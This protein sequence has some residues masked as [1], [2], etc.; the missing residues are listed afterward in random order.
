MFL[1]VFILLAQGN[2]GYNELYNVFIDKN[3]ILFLMNILNLLIYTL[4]K[5]VKQ[6]TL[7][8]Q[9]YTIQLYLIFIYNNMFNI[10]FNFFTYHFFTIKHKIAEMYIFFFTRVIKRNRI[11]K[12]YYRFYSIDYLKI[13]FF[14]LFFIIFFLMWKR[15]N[16]YL[17]RTFIYNFSKFYI[18]SL[19]LCF[20]IA[21][22][23]SNSFLGILISLIAAFLIIFFKLN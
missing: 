3:N 15:R 18:I 17:K 21:P 12:F 11:W 10:F 13:I 23:F 4:Y 16:T 2:F 6:F 1:N 9:F 14:I 7:I 5:F 19:F 8:I 22:L 20:L